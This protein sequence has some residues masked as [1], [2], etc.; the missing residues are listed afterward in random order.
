L[1]GGTFRHAV[2]KSI[3][4]RNDLETVSSSV[5]L[6]RMPTALIVLFGLFGLGFGVGYAIRKRKYRMRSRSYYHGD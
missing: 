6:S 1:L 5:A 2:P 4:G 3:R